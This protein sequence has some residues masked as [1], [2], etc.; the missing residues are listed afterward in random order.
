MIVLG[1]N[2]EGAHADHVGDLQ[3]PPERIKQESGTDALTLGFY[4]NGKA[5]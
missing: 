3:R 4:M 2:G 1:V 5:R